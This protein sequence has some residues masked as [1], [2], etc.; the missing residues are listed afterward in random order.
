MDPHCTVWSESNT[1]HWNVNRKI[2]YKIAD[3]VA[4]RPDCTNVQADLELQSY[5]P[6]THNKNINKCPWP[7][8]KDIRLDQRVL[9]SIP[10]HTCDVCLWA[11]QFTPNCLRYSLNYKTENSTYL[12][13][14]ICAF[15]I[16]IPLNQNWRF[17]TESPSDDPYCNKR[18]SLGFL[19]T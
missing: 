14:F 3:T 13:I 17:V 16:S 18:R 2:F 4:L 12:H 15:S 6:R 19:L 10:V 5:I 9:G 7:S 8:Y 1:V 11:K